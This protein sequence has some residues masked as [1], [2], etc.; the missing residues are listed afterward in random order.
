[1]LMKCFV[2]GCY[3]KLFKF[4]LT[5][6][7]LEP[8]PEQTDLAAK[9]LWLVQIQGILITRMYAKNTSH[10]T[11][12]HT[13]MHSTEPHKHTHTQAWLAYN[14]AA[15]TKESVTLSKPTS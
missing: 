11:H 2:T 8:Y 3:F 1:M 9:V 10:H 4:H 13:Q 5:C 7:H 15:V 14:T 6:T 12:T